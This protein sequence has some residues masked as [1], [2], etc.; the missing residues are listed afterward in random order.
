MFLLRM[1]NTFM[2]L[3]KLY[4][5]EIFGKHTCTDRKMQLADRVPC[6]EMLPQN[7]ELCLVLN[8]TILSSSNL[9][10]IET[11]RDV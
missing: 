5:V 6:V 10:L 9:F 2:C 7:K 8:L 4:M 11:R 1:H 3:V